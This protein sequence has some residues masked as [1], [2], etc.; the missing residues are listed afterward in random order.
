[1]S[2]RV[3][4]TD[5]D[6]QTVRLE[7][8]LELLDRMFAHPGLHQTSSMRHTLLLASILRVKQAARGVQLLAG[9]NC[10]EEIQTLSR[11]IVEVTVNAAYLQSAGYEEFQGFLHFQPQAFYQQVAAL[12][13][14]SPGGG[15]RLLGKLRTL[16]SGPPARNNA[17]LR[18]SAD[19]TWSNKS[20]RDRATAADAA[21]E[22][23]VMKLLVDR[24]YPR[25][26]AAMHGTMNSLEPFMAAL[27]KTGRTAG[28]D[29]DAQKV[30]ALF[31]VNL[32]LFT[33]CLY[34][35]QSFNLRLDRS[36]EDAARA[37]Q[38]LSSLRAE[39]V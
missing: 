12:G 1:M 31:G 21:G 13:D 11:S 17:N 14:G 36:L 33:L 7:H 38:P 34:L 24:V 10:V 35:N 9:E 16:I 15:A 26:H 8:F 6:A 28:P 22:I 18:E 27:D 2:Q 3:L 25:G 23:P 5:L 4:E 32:C 19:P 29:R 39:A 30:E 37:H 20:L